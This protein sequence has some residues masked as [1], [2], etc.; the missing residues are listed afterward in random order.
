M[1]LL[2]S[3]ILMSF[4]NNK[5]KESNCRV[6]SQAT[7]SLSART[8]P[9]EP[10]LGAALCDDSFHFNKHLMSDFCVTDIQITLKI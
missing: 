9:S 8:D 7:S 3:D 1:Y 6:Y 2:G 10:T 5:M 4:E